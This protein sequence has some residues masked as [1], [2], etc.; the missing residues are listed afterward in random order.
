[1]ITSLV[2]APFAIL[3]AG[4]LASAAVVHMYWALGGSIG[5]GL[6]I[7]ETAKGALFRPSP[8]VTLLV[9]LALVLAADLMLAR[10]GLATARIPAWGMHLA[11][12]A[13]AL[14]F[15]GRAVGDF[16]YVGFFKRVRG[17]RFARL[18]TA[19]YSP[20]SLFLAVA[21]GVNV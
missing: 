10:L 3:A 20:L 6:A 9:S 4:I 13:L 16:R 14:A 8:V 18:D 2:A 7:P 19:L 5:V 1:M 11:C 21:V 15:L 12:G 17:S